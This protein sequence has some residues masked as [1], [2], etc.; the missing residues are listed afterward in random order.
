VDDGTDGTQH[1]FVEDR[2]AA[3]SRL[4][5]V[6]R[7]MAVW[8]LTRDPHNCLAVAGFWAREFQAARVP[9]SLLGRS[10][11]SDR[12]GY[13]RSDGVN[14][15]GHNFLAVG[16][17]RALF[18]PTVSQLFD[19]GPVTLDRYLVHDGTPFPHWRE[20]Q[21]LHGPAEFIPPAP[22]PRRPSERR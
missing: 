16:P 2:A 8:A 20:E 3:Q 14:V 17:E 21:E 10:G 4:V 5:I 1:H 11:G 22:T 13:L 9:C 12:G 7:R 6:E 18:D 19:D 15:D